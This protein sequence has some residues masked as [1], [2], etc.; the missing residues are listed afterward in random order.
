MFLRVS[1]GVRRTKLNPSK[2]ARTQRTK[3][4]EIK[5]L[6]YHYVSVLISDLRHVTNKKGY[7]QFVA[8]VFK[9][10]YFIDLG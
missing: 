2:A 1:L 5:M 3:K 7:L 10:I 6:L 9:K 8:L 4:S